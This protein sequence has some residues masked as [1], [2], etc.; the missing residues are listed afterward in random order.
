[1]PSA[2]VSSFLLTLI[3]LCHLSSFFIPVLSLPLSLCSPSILLH[4]FFS[5][6]PSISMPPPPFSPSSSISILVPGA[7]LGRLAYEIA[8]RGYTC[9]GNEFSMH[10]LFGSNFILNRYVWQGNHVCVNLLL[11]VY[12]TC[13]PTIIIVCNNIV[14][15]SLFDMDQFVIV[16][17]IGIVNLPYNHRN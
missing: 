12:C 1:M 2:A 6:S 16:C 15:V 13:D 14:H 9:Q 8:S 7:G 3:L 4:L 5:L 17:N 11:A 10:M